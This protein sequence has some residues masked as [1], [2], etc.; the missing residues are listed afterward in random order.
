MQSGEDG[1]HALDLANNIDVASESMPSEDSRGQVSTPPSSVAIEQEQAA[2]GLEY[3]ITS[4][5]VTIPGADLKP[6]VG[7]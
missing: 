6:N 4:S 5:Q 7:D 2:A 1:V 3:T